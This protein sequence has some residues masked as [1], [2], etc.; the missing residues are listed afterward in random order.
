[1]LLIRALGNNNQQGSSL[2][3]AVIAVSLSVIAINALFRTTNISMQSMSFIENRADRESIRHLIMNGLDCNATFTS[4]A[5]NTAIDCGTS[6]A[7]SG[8]TGGKFLRLR[9]ATVGGGTHHITGPLET[10]GNFANA[11]RIGNWYVRATCSESEQSLVIRTAL[12]DGAGGFAKD[13]LT[14]QV[15]DWNHP[16]ALLFGAGS[17]GT[18][19]CFDNSTPGN[20]VNNNVQ[21]N[22]AAKQLSCI[23]K[24]VN[25]IQAASASSSVTYFCDGRTYGTGSADTALANSFIMSINCASTQGLG[26]N[27]TSIRSA[28]CTNLSAT[29]IANHTNPTIDMLCCTF[30]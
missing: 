10:S 1:M 6:S 24:Y 26:E 2:M 30:Q 12:S 25:P 8:Q 15:L 27:L 21:L 23:R 13:K 20:T 5:V 17:G 9:R 18:P 22:G 28:A 4:Q 7:L 11:G 3:S 29:P 16:K 19:I 14:G